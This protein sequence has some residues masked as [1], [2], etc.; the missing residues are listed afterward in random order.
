M[1]KLPILVGVVNVTPDSFSDGGEYLSTSAGCRHAENLIDQGADIIEIGGDS[2]RPGSVCCGPEEEWRRIE[3][4]VRELAPR[5]RL[6]IDTHHAVVAERALDCGAALIN[7]VTAGSDPTMFAVA[8]RYEA[9]IVCMFSRCSPPHHFGDNPPRDIIAFINNYLD[10][11]SERARAAGIKPQNIIRDT[12]LG[13]FVDSDP[14]RSWT[15]IER[16]DEV[17]AGGGGLMFGS[18]R[19]GFLK[20]PDE[21][22]PHD[23]DLASALTGIAATNHRHNKP[24]PLYIRT[25]NVALQREL[26][27]N[28]TALLD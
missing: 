27:L 24:G 26:L 13:A 20:R 16:Y 19:K 2:T 8:A 15:I 7:D 12:G 6:S 5:L 1:K 11:C 25:H 22:S 18:S 23:R 3:P 17:T 9:P 14:E 21:T 4:I 28:L 10:E